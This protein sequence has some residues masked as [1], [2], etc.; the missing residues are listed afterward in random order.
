MSKI[1]YET[2]V[3]VI[4]QIEKGEESANIIAKN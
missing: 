2:K 1:S 4:R 3:Q